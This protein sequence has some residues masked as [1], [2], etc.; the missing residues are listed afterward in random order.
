MEKKHYKGIIYDIDCTL[1]DTFRMN[2]VPLQRIIKEELNEDWPLERLMPF[3]AYAGMK[4]M[5]ELDIKDK[6]KT[7]ARW[8][9]YV[10][11]F[12]EGANPYPHVEE[13]L[14]TIHAMHI[15]QAIVSSKLRDQYEIDFVSK[16]FDKY[17]DVAVLA[18]DTPYLK[19]DP[20]PVELAIDEMGLSKDEVIY[21]GDALSDYLVCINAGIDFGYATWGS[22]NGEGIEASI[23]LN[24]PLD[25]LK[26]VQD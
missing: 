21:I 3:T 26:L 1:L 24:E 14:K 2:M 23:I 12:E 6:E 20:R 10:N 18:D 7:Y 16:G 13:V 11:E 22:V 9:K 25:I 19:P 4:V 15:Q 8:V 17:M 5:E